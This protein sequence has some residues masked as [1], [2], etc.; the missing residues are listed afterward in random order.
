[1]DL[2]GRNRII[3]VLNSDPVIEAAHKDRGYFPSVEVKPDEAELERRGGSV[4]IVAIDIWSHDLEPH[5]FIEA[6]RINR[7]LDDG[8]AN[9]GISPRL[10][11]LDF[12][13]NMPGAFYFLFEDINA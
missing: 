5:S 8:S 13:S 10:R 3:Q 11:L 7:L 9:R 12:V 1:M 4:G 6:M 2:E